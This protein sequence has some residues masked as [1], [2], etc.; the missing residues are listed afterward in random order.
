MKRFLTII[1]ATFMLCACTG[2]S[3]GGINSN[4]ESAS[5]STDNTDGD[6]PEAL[7]RKNEISYYTSDEVKKIIKENTKFDISEDFESFVPKS[8]SY[9]SYFDYA[10]VRF[11]YRLQGNVRI[12]FPG[13]KI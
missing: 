4:I 5:N 9:L 12:S 3:G 10:P 8:V 2:C 7:K 6:I 11:L 13:R 1:L